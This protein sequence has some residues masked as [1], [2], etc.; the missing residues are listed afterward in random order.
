MVAVTVTGQRHNVAMTRRAFFRIPAVILL[1]VASLASVSASVAH[2]SAAIYGKVVD[3]Q[4]KPVSGV[5]ITVS[6][7]GT[8]IASVSTSTD[9]SYSIN[10]AS[11]NYSI[12]FVS[13]TPTLGSLYAYDLAAPFSQAL[14]VMLTPPTPGRAFVVGNISLSSRAPLSTSTWISYGTG[15]GG[16]GF[17]NTNG[18]FRLTPTAG[19]MGNYDIKGST[20]D[21]NWNFEMIGQGQ[22]PIN[23]DVISNF[24]VPVSTQRVRIVTPAGAPVVGASIQSGV[25]EF[26]M[27]NGT[28]SPIE[29]LG[30]F[31]GRWIYTS[32][33]DANGWTSIP[34]VVMSSPTVG[35]I[36][37]APLATSGYGLQV[38]QKTFGSGDLTLTLTNPVAQINGSVKDRSGIAIDQTQVIYGSTWAAANGS[39]NFLLSQPAGTSSNYNLIYHGDGQN[40]P[41]FAFTLYNLTDNFT[42]TSS[43]TANFVIPTEKVKVKVTDP[44]GAPIANAWVQLLIGSDPQPKGSLTLLSGRKPFSAYVMGQAYTD[45]NGVALVPSIHLD[46]EVTGS[47]T[48]DPGSASP[49]T[50]NKFITPLGLGKDLGFSLQK[51]TV[52]LTGNIKFSDGTPFINPN[53]SFDD[54]KG[55]GSS[56]TADGSNNFSITVAKGTVAPWSFGCRIQSSA[57]NDDPLCAWA[58]GGPTITANSDTVQNFTIPTYKTPIKIVDPSGKGLANVRVD[59]SVGNFAPGNYPAGLINL[60]PGATAFQVAWHAWAKTDANGLAQ[61]PSVRSNVPTSAYVMITPDPTSRYIQRNLAITTGDNSQNVIVLTIL[62]PIINTVTTSIV[63]GAKLATLIGDNFLGATGVSVGNTT[64]SKFTVVDVNHITFTVPTGVTASTVTVTNGGGSTTSGVLRF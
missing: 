27:P 15:V 64:I 11:G 55:H 51:P 30:A 34:M 44:T 43:T 62:K 49:Y 59:L 9:G 21:G 45:A 35:Q 38:F 12:R 2:A 20:P 36:Q 52:K 17:V 24:V 48:V 16:S 1:V 6:Q 57:G 39:G 26:G 7:N 58:S 60:I 40:Y 10:A 32:T 19:A 4:N 63:A 61:V 13:P 28:M 25:G 8:A 50:W 3:N 56:A 31:Q 41:N 18:D 47:I 23:Q 37:V 54:G 53:V 22:Y 33:T 42:L 5:A 46:A 14:T 29:G